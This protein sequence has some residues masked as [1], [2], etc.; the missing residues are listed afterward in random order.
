L[1]FEQGHDESKILW[2]ERRSEDGEIRTH[3]H[4]KD[5]NARRTAAMRDLMGAEDVVG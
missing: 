2:K 3:P 4:D 1:S 5:Y